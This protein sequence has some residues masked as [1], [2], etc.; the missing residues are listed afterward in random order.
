MRED[1]GTE[2]EL[3]KEESEEKLDK[4]K[5]VPVSHTLEQPGKQSEGETES[6][7]TV[8]MMDAA[9][10]LTESCGGRQPMAPTLNILMKYSAQ[11]RQM[12][13]REDGFSRNTDTHAKRNE[14]IGAHH[15]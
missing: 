1:E 11:V 4:S 6:E 9:K 13:A 5:S 15:V 2:D 10:S 8:L 3:S 7:E 14:G 12:M